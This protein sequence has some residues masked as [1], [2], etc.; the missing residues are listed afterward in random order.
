MLG[1][2]V[3]ALA[4]VN[5]LKMMKVLSVVGGTRVCS[6]HQS[7]GLDCWPSRMHS[8]LA[9]LAMRVRA[10]RLHT[11]CSVAERLLPPH[12][13]ISCCGGRG[14]VAVIHQVFSPTAATRAHER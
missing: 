8:M 2:I 9:V 11:L 4:A 1:C 6:L 14:T 10:V 13:L 3:D 7:S 12:R 5:G